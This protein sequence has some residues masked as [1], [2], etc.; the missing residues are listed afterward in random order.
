MC[1]RS[2]NKLNK[3]LT[4]TYQRIIT[5]DNVA[6]LWPQAEERKGK[7]EYL[8][9]A[10]IYYVYLKALRHASHSFTCKYTMPAFLSCATSNW[11][12]RYPIAAYYSSIEPKGWKAELAWLVDLHSGR[13]THISGHPSTTGR[14]QDSESSPAKDRRASQ[15]TVADQCPS[16]YF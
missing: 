15:P 1:T 10:F 11:G 9:S 16:R 8:Y 7:E 12:K 4:P 3:Q 6:A 14:A 2:K 13:F 5:S